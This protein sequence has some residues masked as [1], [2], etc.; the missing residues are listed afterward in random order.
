MTRLLEVVCL[1][2]TYINYVTNITLYLSREKR[3]AKQ[4][5][6]EITWKKVH[7]H[8]PCGMKALENLILKKQFINFEML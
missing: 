6:R 2:R 8:I 5:R 7:T 1:S 3:K 4:R